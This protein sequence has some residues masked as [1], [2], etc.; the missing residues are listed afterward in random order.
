MTSTKPSASNPLGN[1][2]YPGWTASGGANWVGYLAKE[3]NASLLYSYNFAYGGA[4][5]NA[6]LVKP[7]QSTV[8][9]FIDQVG[10]FSS[11]IASHPSYA[12][13]TA[14]NSLFAIWLGVNDVGNSYYQE[15]VQTLLP[16]IMD[17]YFGQVQILYNAGARNF[18]L[19]NVPRKRSC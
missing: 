18:A 14:E 4:T 6:S 7:Y 13:W 8:K 2:A 9:S 10:Q 11:S 19:L 1:P 3:Y 5:V 15:D 17:S 16:K 12:P